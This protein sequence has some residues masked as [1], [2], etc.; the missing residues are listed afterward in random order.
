M[1]HVDT[2]YMTGCY[3]SALVNGDYSGLSDS[4]HATFN[5]WLFD[6]QAGHA[7][8]YDVSETCEFRTDCVSDLMANCY[9]L[10]VY[11]MTPWQPITH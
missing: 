5:E 8:I 1:E 3:L 10:Q 11:E 4:D 6:Y 9:E 2:L 7:Y